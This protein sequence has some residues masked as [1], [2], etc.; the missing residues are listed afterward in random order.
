MSL[1]SSAGEGRGRTANFGPGV[2]GRDQMERV[3][4]AENRL[5][6]LKV[7]GSKGKGG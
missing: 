7:S 3:G 4:W 5:G 6:Q 2:K 1:G